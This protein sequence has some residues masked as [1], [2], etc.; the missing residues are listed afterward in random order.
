MI[1]TWY[2]GLIMEPEDPR[3][4]TVNGY[5]NLGCR[6]DECYA[7]NAAYQVPRARQRRRLG[8]PEGDP[9]HGTDNGY[10]NYG[11]RCPECVAARAQVAYLRRH[12]ALPAD[13]HICDTTAEAA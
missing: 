6:C 5:V 13:P 12:A 11:D 7:A 10:T 8:L 4:G 9:R 1:Q 3:H 2:N